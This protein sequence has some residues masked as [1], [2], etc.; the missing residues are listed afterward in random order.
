MKKLFL[1]SI[2]IVALI[3]SNCSSSK[4]STAP[5]PTPV[6]PG[7][8]TVTYDANVLPIIESH[9]APCHISGKGKK[10][11]LN[12]YDVAS[13]KIDGMIRRISLQKGQ[14]GFMPRNHDRL[15]D[16]LIQVFIDWRAQGL[17]EK[18]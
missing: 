3:F 11:P 4:K 10:A 14:F 18:K 2:L 12:H 9:C 1:P 7:S 13:S 8:V 15:S 17:V 16:S 5:A 6:A